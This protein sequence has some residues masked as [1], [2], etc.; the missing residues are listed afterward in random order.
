MNITLGFP[1]VKGFVV[2]LSASEARQLEPNPPGI[3]NAFGESVCTWLY[4]DGEWVTDAV[5]TK[6]F[7][8]NFE[9]TVVS[10]SYAKIG[11]PAEMS[12]A[13]TLTHGIDFKV[14]TS[15]TRSSDSI[16][17]LIKDLAESVRILNEFDDE[18]RAAAAPKSLIAKA[19]AWLSSPPDQELLLAPWRLFLVTLPPNAQVK[20]DSKSTCPGIFSTWPLLTDE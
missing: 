18:Q 6:V 19:L 5:T 3:A 15:S 11:S 13:V 2:L 12:R 9:S 14:G 16:T 17:D 10:I 4:A 8:D 20:F 7:I 1:R